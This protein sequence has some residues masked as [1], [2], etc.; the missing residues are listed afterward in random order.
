[1]EDCENGEEKANYS[2]NASLKKQVISKDIG[3]VNKKTIW[4]FDWLDN[5]GTFA[6]NLNRR[7]FDSRDFLEKMIAY[8][9]MTWS[10]ISRQTHD[11][12][13][14]KH[15]YLPYNGLSKDAKDRIK[16]KHLSEHTDA[17]FSFA[18]Q[19]LIRII[20][21][22]DGAFFHVVWYDPRHEF[23]PT[24]RQKSH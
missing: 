17:I 12:G 10:D 19:N 18:L 13:K 9:N 5:D 23:Y 2:K 21:I 6:F 4:L 15:H 1:M 20:G 8:S 16:A 24:K 3:T 22:R 14:S 11:D 7:D